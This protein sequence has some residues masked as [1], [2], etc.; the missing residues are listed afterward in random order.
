MVDYAPHATPG[1]DNAIL[2]AA[3]ILPD[4]IGVIYNHMANLSFPQIN[5]VTHRLTELMGGIYPKLYPY[6]FVD[7]HLDVVAKMI[8]RIVAV[9]VELDTSRRPGT[10]DAREPGWWATFFDAMA[11]ARRAQAKRIMEAPDYEEPEWRKQMLMSRW[12][13]IEQVSKRANDFLRHETRG[14]GSHNFDERYL[15][16]K[17][18]AMQV[19]MPDAR[20]TRLLEPHHLADQWR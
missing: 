18:K 9:D 7:H 14:K 16:I 13:L 15:R 6:W 20:K 10:M 8:D 12:H 2:E 4:G 17:T 19:L 11:P 5:A 1:F 3:S